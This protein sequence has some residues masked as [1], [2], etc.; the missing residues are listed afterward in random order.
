M[1]EAALAG[2]IPGE[3]SLRRCSGQG[4]PGMAGIEN[5]HAV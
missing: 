1:A 5:R 3:A 2:R 4:V